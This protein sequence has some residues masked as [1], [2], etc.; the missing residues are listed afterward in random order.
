MGTSGFS[1]VNAVMNLQ[2]PLNLWNFLINC[3]NIRFLRRTLS[4]GVHSILVC[5][6]CYCV[7]SLWNGF[8]STLQ[9][10][11][12]ERGNVFLVIFFY[13]F[14][15]TG[16]DDI[17]FWNTVWWNLKILDDLLRN[18]ICWEDVDVRGMR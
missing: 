11:G 16:S 8:E 2:V 6:Y 13:L 5:N 10:Y 12:R 3:K 17:I 7:L 14:L 9:G 1:L 18:V 4:C 15:Q